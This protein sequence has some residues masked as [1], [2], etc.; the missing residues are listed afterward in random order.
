[1]QVNAPFLGYELLN[2]SRD[3]SGGD[4][5]DTFLKNL[6]KQPAD[7]YYR[8]SGISYD[9]NEYGHRCKN[10][11]EIDLDNYILFTGCS[12]TEGIGLALED[13]Y[14]YKVANELGCDYYNLAIG[15]TGIDVMMHNL[16]AWFLK[17]E[18]KPR[19]LVIQWPD[20]TRFAIVDDHGNA[21]PCGFWKTD[22]EMLK[23][24]Y[25]ADTINFFKSRRILSLLLTNL[26]GEDSNLISINVLR[27][28]PVDE[29]PLRLE[30][31]DYARDM[32]H[33]GIESHKKLSEDILAYIR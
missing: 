32:S 3:F 31:L 17:V 23:F 14:S 22:E 24:M 18:K 6:S 19:H 20:E 9:Y 12:H 5:E 10:I 25:Y 7:W 26:M 4:E 13:T 30:I 27:Q 28:I 11:S 29:T 15:G 16:V 1:M 33:P 8:T 2:Q 21:D